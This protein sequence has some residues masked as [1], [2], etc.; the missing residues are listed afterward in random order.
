[1]YVKAAVISAGGQGTRLA[2]VFPNIPKA[3]VKVFGKPI[4]LDQIDKLYSHGISQFYFILGHK[5]EEI[6]STVE[7]HI[8]GYSDINVTFLVEESP[9]GSGGGLLKFKEFLPEVFLFL[10]CDIYFDIDIKSL[11]TAFDKRK[12]DALL[13]VHPNDHPHDSDLI[14]VDHDN[15]VLSVKSHP[16]SSIDFPGNL[17]NAAFYVIKKSALPRYENKKID[18]AQDVVPEM[19]KNKKV[20]YAHKTIEFLKDM[21]TPDRLQKVHETYR[22]RYKK[23]KKSP[24]VFLDRDGTI[25]KIKI[26]E[27]ITSVDKLT[28]LDYAAAAIKAIRQ[29]GYFCVCITNQPVI[30]RGDL[31]EADLKT[32]H[33]RLEYLLG[34]EGAY[35]D[36]IAHCPHHPHSGYPGEVKSLKIDCDCRKPKTGLFE[37]ISEYI[38]PD[39]QAS[40]MVGDSLSDI[41]AGKSFGLNTVLLNDQIPSDINLCGS[42]IQQDSVV[43]NL[44]IFSNLLPDLNI[45]ND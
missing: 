24:V 28:L 40:W 44:Y 22:A 33:N 36:A 29:K 5:S 41:Q 2:K 26:G 42:L 17:V 8:S 9:L 15:R 6:K 4:V 34:L 21:G 11:I 20:I 18:F 16:H 12:C 13:I 32:V 3:L 19:L 10:Y 7:D 43:K 39:L 25:N 1:M 37:R 35:L 45:Y 30:A 14:V 38:Q 27:Y 23:N 31:S